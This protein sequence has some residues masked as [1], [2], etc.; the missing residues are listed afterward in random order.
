[1][2]KDSKAANVALVL[3]GCGVYD[4][5]EIHEAVC[6]LL[7]LKKLGANVEFFAPQMPQKDVVNHLNA[8]LVDSARNV[9]EE[10]ARIARGNVAPASELDVSKFDAVVF[11]GGFGAAK[12]LSSFAFD[13]ADCKVCPDVERIV[14]T[15]VG[16]GKKLA[17]ICIAPVIAAKVIGK[18]V[19]LTIGNDKATAAAI[20]SMG[21]KHVECQP[22]EFVR[23]DNFKVYSTPAYMLAAD[24]TDVDKG[25]GAM[26]A[27]MLA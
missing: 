14:A 10:S 12:N 8:T 9:L 5:S 15:A 22:T 2:E 17:F 21:A 23:D 24:I 25:V 4:G 27:D 1:M 20:E 6:A 19:K 18:G 11:P 3:S 13:G 26:L 16:L 7:N